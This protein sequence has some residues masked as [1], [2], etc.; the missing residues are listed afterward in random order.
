[1]KLNDIQK[2]FLMFLVGCIGTRSLFVYI[3]KTQ[4][5]FLPFL[6]I[7]ALGA[8]IGFAYIYIT[9]ARS[10]GPAPE[11][12]GAPIWWNDLRP[13]HSL[14]YFM[15]AISAIR[16]SKNAWVFLL[17]D[18]LI[19]LASFLAFHYSNGDFAQLKVPSIHS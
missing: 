9:G 6:G 13:V 1:M 12:L 10:S 5:A 11:T 19:G 8:A 18:V 3:A 16:G 15:F 17:I 4:L 2:R 14:L 7:L